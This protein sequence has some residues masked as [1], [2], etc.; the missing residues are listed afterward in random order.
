MISIDSQQFKDLIHESAALRGS[1]QFSKAI[2]LL[3][4][5]LPDMEESC[6]LNTY[7]ELFLAAKELGDMV[8]TCRYAK[9][10]HGIEPGLPAIQ[11]YL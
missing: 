11:P 2:E 4:E 1:G 3:E 6:L 9:A 10:L 7:H 8:L 5:A